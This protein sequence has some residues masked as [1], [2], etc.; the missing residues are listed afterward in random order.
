MSNKSVFGFFAKERLAYTKE[1]LLVCGWTEHETSW[2]PPKNIKGDLSHM[3]AS[4]RISD[5]TMIQVA[6]DESVAKGEE[7]E[8][9]E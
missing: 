1:Y 5:A 4:F 7:N 3:D 6:Y 2:R 8:C 9:N